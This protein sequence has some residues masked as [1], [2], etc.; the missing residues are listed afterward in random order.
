MLKFLGPDGIWSKYGWAIS[1]AVWVIIGGLIIIAS[2]KHLKIGTLFIGAF[3]TFSVTGVLG[4]M[5][6][7]KGV[8]TNSKPTHLQ[9]I[10]DWFTKLLLGAGLVEFKSISSLLWNFSQNLG[11]EIDAD[12]GKF[13]VVFVLTG[14]G[15]LGLI[16]GYLWS[17]LHYGNEE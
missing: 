14:F 9:Q 11:A 1:V 5:F 16:T 3:S 17:Q 10:A 13:I 8:E 6:G 12:Y 2:T 15:A 7:I 4:F